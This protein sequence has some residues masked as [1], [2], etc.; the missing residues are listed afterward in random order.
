MPIGGVELTALTTLVGLFVWYLKNQTKQQA[1]RESDSYIERTDRQT[2]RDKE[3][4]EEREYYR[5]VIKTE[6]RT[7]EV[8]NTQGIVSQ[9]EMMKD[10][11]EHNGHSEELSKKVLGA[12]DILCDKMNGGSP[13]SIA[14][15]NKL[16]EYEKNGVI[17]NRRM[18][19]QKT[20]VD[21]RL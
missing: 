15:K 18:K 12:F 3:Q 6:L 17:V 7:N 21:R 5:D 14:L 10:F 2:K 13:E 11:K 4:K 16:K 1:K 20:K 8:L 19:D 9:K